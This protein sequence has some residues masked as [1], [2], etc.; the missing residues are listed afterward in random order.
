MF[1]YGASG[2]GL[3]IL[4]ILEEL[5]IHVE[6]FV[7]DFFEKNQF[8]GIQV[9]KPEI[10]S[11]RKNAK[12]ILAIGDNH[13]R[14]AVSLQLANEFIN[15][16]HPSAVISKSAQIGHGSVLMASAVINPHVH[17]GK[18]VIINTAASVD[19]ECVIA[20]YVHISP[21]ATLAGRVSVGQCTHIGAGS[22]IIQG[23][24]IGSNC[25]IGAGA[26]VLRDVPDGAVMVGNPARLLRYRS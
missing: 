3:V 14:E 2:H 4:D 19:H 11:Q 10:L 24:N 22:V 9:V 16:F 18:H 17:I 7:D 20:D 15:A 6:A 5:G 8:H 13:I 1:I 26:V 12:V 23:I 25:T 21:N